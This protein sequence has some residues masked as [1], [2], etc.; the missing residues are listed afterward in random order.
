MADMSVRAT[1]ER[2]F[3]VLAAR[4]MP[5]EESGRPVVHWSV[6]CDG[7][8]DARSLAA[9]GWLSAAGSVSHCSGAIVGRR[10]CANT[11]PAKSMAPANKAQGA[12]KQN[13]PNSALGVLQAS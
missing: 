3:C 10:C 8:G 9:Q 12:A 1:P 5:P 6:S 7:D 4:I 11:G 2:P 13:M